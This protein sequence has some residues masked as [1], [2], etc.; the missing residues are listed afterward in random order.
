M[1]KQARNAAPCIIF[2]DEIDAIVPTRGAGRS[3]SG[4]SERVVI[5]LLTAMD[6]I[7]E[8]KE[9]WILAA[10]NRLDI[11][12]PA[13]LR[14]GRFDLILELPPADERTC[15]EILR[16][17]TAKKPL[18]DD[19]DLPALIKDTVGLTGAD[20]AGL[21]REAAMLAIREFLASGTGGDLAA[22]R[23]GQRH[24][25]AARANVLARQGA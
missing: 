1:F 12:D 17:H 6:G 23:I 7:E 11:I 21:C 19:V 10:T 16:V 5:P 20:L 22:F 3:D 8:L 15:L 9:V 24:F 4:V 13:I 2:F 25:L 14:P 18:G